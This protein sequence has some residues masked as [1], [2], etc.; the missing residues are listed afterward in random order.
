MQNP[1]V[2]LAQSSQLTSS[3]YVRKMIKDVGIK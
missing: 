3:I 2:N 1:K